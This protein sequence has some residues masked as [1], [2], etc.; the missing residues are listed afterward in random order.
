MYYFQFMT[1]THVSN[2]LGLRLF[3]IGYDPI[4]YTNTLYMT[5]RGGWQSYIL[6]H[7]SPVGGVIS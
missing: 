5:D 4:Q 3:N 2:R 7:A 6:S 1:Q